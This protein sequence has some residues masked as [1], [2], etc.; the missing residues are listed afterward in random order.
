MNS[1]PG[2]HDALLTGISLAEKRVILAISRVNGELWHA[3]VH[4]VQALQV[5]EFREGNI[6]SHFEVVA[7]SEP[8]RDILKRLFTPPHPAA[9]QQ[10]H[11][12]HAQLLDAK[13]RM[14]RDSEAVLVMVIP[15]YGAELA[16]FGVSFEAF[17]APIDTS[18]QAVS[19]A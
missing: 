1:V 7:G 14:V 18:T 5:D 6:I 2:F 19:V 16:A 3:I 10:Y 13:S 9:E 17:P 11:D 15:S 12:A 8:S 4:G